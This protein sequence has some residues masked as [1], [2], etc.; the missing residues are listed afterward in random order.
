M[1]KTLTFASMHFTI[2]FSIAWLLTGDLLVGGLV[3]TVEPACN[4]VAF[5]F[6]EKIWRKFEAR[7]ARQHLE[8]LEHPSLINIPTAFEI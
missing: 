3:A 6:H 7:R 5:F 4:T 2:A 8:G 1:T